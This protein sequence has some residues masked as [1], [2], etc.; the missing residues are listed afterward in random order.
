MWPEM[1]RGDRKVLTQCKSFTCR[2]KNFQISVDGNGANV[3]KS[4]R[5]SQKCLAIKARTLLATVY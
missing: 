1:F 4:Q 2:L 3:I 5:G